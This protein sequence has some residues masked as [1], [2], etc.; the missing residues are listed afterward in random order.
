MKLISKIA[1]NFL[2]ANMLPDSVSMELMKKHL[3]ILLGKK[4]HRSNKTLEPFLFALLSYC[5]LLHKCPMAILRSSSRR[6]KEE[7][8]QSA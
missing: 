5:V 3:N 1:L 7:L 8:L 4:S 2:S 6:K